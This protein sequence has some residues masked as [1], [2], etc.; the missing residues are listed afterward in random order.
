[1]LDLKS[2]GFGDFL[3]LWAV[4]VVLRLRE[5]TGGTVVDEVAI[6]AYVKFLVFFEL[7]EA[8]MALQ[9]VGLIPDFG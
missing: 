9:T 6:I 5:T 1:M 7:E 4:D 2:I 8:S 3:E